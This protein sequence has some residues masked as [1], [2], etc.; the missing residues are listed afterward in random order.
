MLSRRK[1]RSDR[2]P[3]SDRL[4]AEQFWIANTEV[5][6]NVKDVIR[7]RKANSPV[8]E[9][10]IHRQYRTNEAI[11]LSFLLESGVQRMS[12]TVFDDCKPWFVKPGKVDT[13]LCKVC[14][15]FRLAKKAATYNYE[16]LLR[17]YH[18]VRILGRFPFS[19]FTT[20]RMMRRK[21]GGYT[22]NVKLEERLE[23]LEKHVGQP[24]S[25]VQMDSVGHYW[26]QFIRCSPF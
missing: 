5:S 15:D 22:R 7:L 24:D 21:Y 14:E 20:L 25:W 2:L 10:M 9:H 8:I 4:L 11:H 18:H 1:K 23:N 13:C 6:P 3:E 19:A 26:R 16:L 12:R 17:P